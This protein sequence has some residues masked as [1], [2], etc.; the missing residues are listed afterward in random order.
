V[1]KIVA[2]IRRNPNLTQKEFVEYWKTVHVPLVKKTL[3]GLVKYIGSFPVGVDSPAEA[4]VADFDA[5]VELG[6]DSVESMN[7][8]MSSPGFLSENR[9]ISSAKLMDLSRIQS[10]VVEEIVV[11]L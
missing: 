5:L 3:P 7:A 6:F 1:I 8:A 11:P 2:L 4:S 10:L 9:Q